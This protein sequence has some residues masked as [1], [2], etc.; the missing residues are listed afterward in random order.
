MFQKMLILFYYR[1]EFIE[2]LDQ[3]GDFWE[4]DDFEGEINTELRGL[5]NISYS[6]YKVLMSTVYS[7]FVVIISKPI[8]PGKELPLLCYI[9]NRFFINDYT[10]YVA[11]VF[12]FAYCM[13]MVIGYDVVF[14][15]FCL[16][17]I[18]QLKLI[19][20]TLRNLPFHETNNGNK[21]D[22][23]LKLM[24]KCVKHHQQLIKM[25]EKMKKLYS[26]LFLSQ[27]SMTTISMSM[28][29]YIL[30]ESFMVDNTQAIKSFF[31]FG[32]V[33]FQFGFYVFPAAEVTS[34]VSIT[35]FKGY[36]LLC[37]CN[38]RPKGL[39]MHYMKAFGTMGIQILKS[40]P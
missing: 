6:F 9:P 32:C 1:K 35:N 33:F 39:Q 11:E 34:E 19:K 29:L 25:V 20:H 7:T 18:I 10:V 30:V 27:I 23:C 38:F 36:W 15:A 28:E 4:I 12:L 22:A 40:A 24:K 2:L 16:H 26:F 5:M 17:I 13:I 8:L 21:N 31:Y 3:C 37:S 14:A